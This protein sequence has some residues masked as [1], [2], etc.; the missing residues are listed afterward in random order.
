MWSS[1]GIP[2][3]WTPPV[4]ETVAL[5]SRGIDELFKVI[6]DHAMYASQAS[7]YYLARKRA[8]CM[9]ELKDFIRQDINQK[10][11]RQLA[12]VEDIDAQIGQIVQGE[13]DIYNVTDSLLQAIE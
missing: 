9:I 6:D 3:D 12:D 4:V 8:N 10:I 5:K 13:A 1:S 7:E 11:S 2:R